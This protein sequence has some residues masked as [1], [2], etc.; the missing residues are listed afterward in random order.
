MTTR[1][2]AVIHP[3]ETVSAHEVERSRG[4]TIQVLLGPED[5]VPNFATRLFTL[6]PG[7]RIPCHSHDSIEHE[8]FILEGEMTLGLDEKTHRVSPGDCIL[9]PAG[10]EHW[11]ENRGIVPVRFLCVVPITASYHTTWLEEPA[12]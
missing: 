3:I 2:P 11:Y 6:L 7:G 8:Q 10:T 12:E 1:I 9:I 5:N 4:A